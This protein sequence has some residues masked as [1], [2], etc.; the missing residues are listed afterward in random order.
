M[1]LLNRIKIKIGKPYVLKPS[2]N[3]VIKL[4]KK[5][6]LP[7]FYLE[8]NGIFYITNDGKA[9]IC[10]TIVYSNI[11]NVEF[12]TQSGPMLLI[13]GKVNII[14]NPKSNNL[15]IRNGVGIL[16]NN[17]LIF[18]ISTNKVTFYD[19]AKFFKEKGCLNA[20]YLDGYVSKGFILNQGI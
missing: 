6:T 16:P 2:N 10:K 12:A 19:F 17:D 8:P 11:A 7:N 20:L 18:A 13:N 5:G 4:D 15:N 14:F 9:G 3:K 1:F